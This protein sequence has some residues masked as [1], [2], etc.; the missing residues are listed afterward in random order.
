M[1]IKLTRLNE[2][3]LREDHGIT[4]LFTPNHAAIKLSLIGK[5]KPTT[6]RYND[7][8][9]A[10]N[11]DIREFSPYMCIY[12]RAPYVANIF[13]DEDQIYL[14]PEVLVNSLT[15]AIEQ[16]NEEFKTVYPIKTFYYR[17]NKDGTQSRRLLEV[18][19]ESPNYIE[20]IDLDKGEFRRFLKKNVI[21]SIGTVG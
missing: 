2:R 11:F 12:L 18:H 6:K 8:K 19:S 7:G 3:S 5:P 16:F 14:L 4:V 9:C 15:K 10:V 1:Q 20:G 21:G 13:V 17:S